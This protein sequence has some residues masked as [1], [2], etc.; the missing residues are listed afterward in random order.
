VDQYVGIKSRASFQR[1][2]PWT[3]SSAAGRPASR[4]VAR[5]F[6]ARAGIPRSSPAGRS[7]P[8]KNFLVIT[9][10]GSSTAFGSGGF[11]L[12]ARFRSRRLWLCRRCLPAVVGPYRCCASTAT[13][14]YRRS[15][16]P[17]GA[18]VWRGASERC[19]ARENLVRGCRL[20]RPVSP[21]CSAEISYQYPQKSPQWAWPLPTSIR[22]SP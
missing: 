15:F 7:N 8:R 3:R 4:S 1:R 14:G 11:R 18:C 16:S 19:G 10:A 9:L 6:V 13:I 12:R 20:A 17:L 21:R 5:D 2:H 22:T